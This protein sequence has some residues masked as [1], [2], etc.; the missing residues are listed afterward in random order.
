MLAFV[1]HV[2][3]MDSISSNYWIELCPGTTWR[4]PR[5]QPIVTAVQILY[6][7]TLGSGPQSLE[8]FIWLR[9]KTEAW[10]LSRLQKTTLQNSEESANDEALV[11]DGG[12]RE[13]QG[14]LGHETVIISSYV[15]FRVDFLKQRRLSFQVLATFSLPWNTRKWW[16]V[17]PVH[18]EATAHPLAFLD[19]IRVMTMIWIIFGHCITFSCAVANNL[20]VYAQE[21]FRRWTFQ[22][23]ISA[24]LSVDVF[25][26]M[27]GLLCVYTALPRFSAAQGVASRAR[28]WLMFVCHRVL[29]LTPAYLLTM[30]VYA[31]L[32]HHLHDGPFFPQKP[33]LLDSLYCRRHGWVT[34]LNNLIYPKEPCMGWSWYLSNDLQFS[35]ILAPIFI[36]LTSW[37][38]VAGMMFAAALVISSILATFG[39]AYKNDYLPGALSIVDSFD[40]IYVKPY[41]RWGTYAIGLV[42]GWILLK[43]YTPPKQWSISRNVVF[44]LVLLSFAS[45]FC[46]STLYGLYG[47]VSQTVPL[48]STGVSALY[49]SV[50]RP[51][52]ILGIAI[53]C[54][55]CTN[56]YAPPIR[57]LLAWTGFRPF[58]RLTYGVYLVHPLVILF[59][60]LGALSPIMLDNLFLISLFLAVFTLSYG[61]AYLLS[62]MTE[63]PI[64]GCEK[65]LGLR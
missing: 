20:F 17:P 23:M 42:L 27:S 14:L 3:A 59:L 15:D 64:L 43:Q 60:C 65:L 50:H 54:F 26:M 63:S 49:T 11:E 30:L 24:F 29:R 57:S 31:G 35:V 19:G 56:G 12:E 21:N 45:V 48:P 51:V 52:F 36:S 18:V 4:W 46:L 32:F 39:I 34:Y 44:S 37:N 22:V 7:R 16:A 62:M 9:W 5:P 33:D 8:L 2:H 47:Y 41:T 1:F 28:F 58:A 61:F 55:L 10:N 53:V 40:T 13:V 6:Q 38:V 25:F